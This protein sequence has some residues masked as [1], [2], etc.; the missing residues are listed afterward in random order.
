[1]IKGKKRRG[2]GSHWQIIGVVCGVTLAA[3]AVGDEHTNSSLPGAI[4]V[5]GNTT[6]T[7]DQATGAE[8][9]LEGKATLNLF[10]GRINNIKATESLKLLSESLKAGLVDQ[11]IDGASVD[12]AIRLINSELYAENALIVSTF[13]PGMQFNGRTRLYVRMRRL[14]AARSLVQVME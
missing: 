1:M 3:S 4:V 12:A 9:Q 13:K 10:S 7:V 2:A 6:V 14:P 5:P 8:Y 11:R